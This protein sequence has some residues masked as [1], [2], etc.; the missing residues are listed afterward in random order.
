MRWRETVDFAGPVFAVM[1]PVSPSMARKLAADIPELAV[2][3]TLIDELELNREQVW[4][5]PAG[6][7]KPSASRTHSTESIS[8]LSRVTARWL[9]ASNVTCSKRRPGRVGGATT[10]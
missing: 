5:T 1:V 6:W 8:F 4:T 3:Q 2:P 7:S 10:G 9:P